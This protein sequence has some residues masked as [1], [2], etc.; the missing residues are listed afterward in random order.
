[1]HEVEPK[2]GAKIKLTF[3]DR[4]KILF[5]SVPATTSGINTV[6]NSS[7]QHKISSTS[8]NSFGAE[9]SSTGLR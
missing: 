3:G 7:L 1:V 2:L 5:T 9:N 4:L 8:F 6:L